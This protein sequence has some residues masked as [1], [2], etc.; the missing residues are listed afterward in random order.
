MRTI[1]KNLP[2][3]HGVFSHT[4]YDHV[5]DIKY[6]DSMTAT[7]WKHLSS[8]LPA[9][10]TTSYFLGSLICHADKRNKKE[11]NQECL[12]L[13]ISRCRF[14]SLRSSATSF[15]PASFYSTQ[16]TVCEGYDRKTE[17]DEKPVFTAEEVAQ[18][19][20]KDS[21][22]IWVTL[23]NKVY[24]ITDFAKEHK[25]GSLILTAAGGPIDEFWGYWAYHLHLK[26]PWT[27]LEQ[28]HI[29]YLADTPDESWNDKLAAHYAQEPTRDDRQKVLI[30]KP[31]CSETPPDLQSSLYTNNSVFYVRNHAPVPRL[32]SEHYK[33]CLECCPMYQAD[34]ESLQTEI[35]LEELSK[36]FTFMS[37]AS[38]LQC[39]GNRSVDLQ[40]ISPTAF[41]N[42]PFRNLD[43]GMMGNAVWSGYSLRDLLI[44]KFPWLN[45]LT[46]TEL[47]KYH[48]EFEGVDDYVTSTPLSR[49]LDPTAD[50][51]LA[52]QMNGESLHPDH[53][54]PVRA[55]LPG[56]A[57]ARSC[58][59]L[60]KITIIPHE[61]EACF[62]QT[63]YRDPYGKAIQEM[64]MQS[65][66]TVKEKLEN[67]QWR[68][69]GVAWGGG[70]GVGVS[71][72]Q[73]GTDEKWIDVPL[74][75]WNVGP[76]ASREWSWIV[77]DCI[78]PSTSGVF[79]CRIVDGDGT[80]QPQALWYPKGYLSNPWHTL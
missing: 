80:I 39:A 48:V 55:F 25:G 10:A 38:V 22:E 42:T 46:E 28:C 3:G 34:K 4:Q 18:R 60:H 1:R 31:W 23:S 6:I 69:S 70:S 57:G 5:D 19:N 47:S 35:S 64:P 54:F 43:R 67:G 2:R 8:K 11:C 56:I 59:W 9:W 50:S 71:K 61:S 14:A 7:R 51:M 52:V 44:A 77:F 62:T 49:V 66:L 78:V 13:P 75:N 32:S 26:E 29:G 72:I 24:D 74:Q 12:T 68:V 76:R 63:Y 17:T 15:L 36:D 45:H 37:I 16:A 33:I 30:D 79:T 40:N 53:G 65:F 41:A 27:T 58:K 20:G 21:A 73:I